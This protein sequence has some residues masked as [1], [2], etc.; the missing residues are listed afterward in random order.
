MSSNENEETQIRL[1]QSA[2]GNQAEL[3]EKTQLQP[4]PPIQPTTSGIGRQLAPSVETKIVKPQPS[5]AQRVSR[6]SVSNRDISKDSSSLAITETKSESAIQQKS[7]DTVETEE[8]V[9][10]KMGNTATSDQALDDDRTQ[11]K[12]SVSKVVSANVIDDSTQLKSQAESLQRS[13]RAADKLGKNLQARRSTD[14]PVKAVLKQNTPPERSITSPVTSNPSA[15]SSISVPPTQS[16]PADSIVPSVINQRFVL[17]IPLGSGGM[18]TVYKAKDL[19]KVEAKDRNPWVAV[20]LLNSAF[21]EHPDAFISLQREARKTQ[22]LAHPNIVRVYDFDRA[23][24]MVYMTMELLEGDALD[25][26][27]RKNP[28]GLGKEAAFQLVRE[29]GGALVEAHSLNIIHSDFKPGNIFYTNDKKSKVFDFGIARAVSK[30]DL[31]DDK[32]DS[33]DTVFD[34]GSLGALTPTYASYEMLTGQVPS[35]SDDLYALGCVAYQ[36]LTGKH[37][38]NRVP[39]DKALKQKLKPNAVDGLTRREARALRKAVAIK[40]ED[41]YATVDE[42]LHDFLPEHHRFTRKVK[43]ALTLAVLVVIGGGIKYGEVLYEEQQRTEALKLEQLKAEKKSVEFKKLQTLYASQQALKLDV[44]NAFK[45]EQGKAADLQHDL[46]QQVNLSAFADTYEWQLQTNNKIT[47]LDK[48][49]R[50]DSWLTPFYASHSGSDYKSILDDAQKLR[51]D[52]VTR[53][54]SWIGYFRKKVSNVYIDSADDFLAIPD[55]EKAQGMYALA[56]QY[57]PESAPVEALEGRIQQVELNLLKEEQARKHAVMS[58]KYAE[59][60]VKL[61]ENVASC[62]AKLAGNGRANNFSYDI[63]S[64]KAKL[65]N[66]KSEYPPLASQLELDR[67]AHMK[68][69]ANCIQ[70]YGFSDPKGA[71]HQLDIAA[72]TFPKDAALFHATTIRPFNTCKASFAEKG[73]RYTCQDRFIDNLHIKGPKLVVVPAKAG[74][75]MFAMSKYEISESEFNRYCESSKA[76]KASNKKVV[77]LPVTGRSPQQ[78]KGY[79]QWLSKKTGFEYVLPTYQQWIYAAT[80]RGSELDKNRNCQL[81]VRGVNKGL[82]LVPANVG[83]ANKWGL[84]NH[85]GNAQEWVVKGGEDIMVGGS[86]L[87]AMENCTLTAMQPLQSKDSSVNGFRLVR[88]IGLNL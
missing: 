2:A 72:Q 78:I 83:E 8:T 50:D 16:E 73:R 45:V 32:N 19:R 62:A 86:R 87:T 53:T 66:L 69:L 10:V 88:K 15:T 35:P 25:N 57:D 27:F 13:R 59:A 80:A 4:F 20:K 36:S 40:Q 70:L 47:E 84:V 21:K 26:V 34:A 5:N 55:V 63:Y 28:E 68:E 85:V 43:L 51:M 76:C 46:D 54:E 9:L 11:L 71:K 14:R 56:A 65:N 22:G 1:A 61:N 64:L 74:I 82:R 30:I 48:V 3:D 38:Y 44:Q 49:Y 58:V 42:F 17:D 7:P 18:G 12:P 37:P 23:G 79:L 77:E 67:H 81:S 41:R 31:D 60:N 39:A 6:S 75:D 33:D 52:A 29:C 24:D